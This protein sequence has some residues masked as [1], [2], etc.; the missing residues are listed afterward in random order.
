MHESIRPSPSE[1]ERFAKVALP[2]PLTDSFTYAIPDEFRGRVFVGCRVEVSF[3]RRLMSGI[4]VDVT[5]E[6]DVSGIK[7]IRRL[8]ETYLPSS[9]IQLTRW[10]ASYYGCSIGEAAQSVLPPLLKPARSRQRLAGRLVLEGPAA[11]GEME[12]VL[13]RAPKQLELAR[14]LMHA[15]GEASIER[16]LGEWGFS[17][18]HVKGLVDK[19]IASLESSEAE[20]SLEAIEKSVTALT[21]DQSQAMA[22]VGRC[23]EAGRFSPVLLH[24][25]TGS[26]KTE[27]YIRAASQAVSMGG[28]CIV[29]VPE[30]GLLPQ[31]TVRYRR[32]FGDG[33]AILHSRLTGAERFAIW[34]SIESGQRRIVLGPR[35]AV[36]GPVRNL[37][38]IIVDEEQDDSYKQDD[39]PRYHARHVALMRGKFEGLT[40][41]LGS[42]TPSAESFHH[43]MTGRYERVTLRSRVEGSV[44]PAVNFV[45]MR[46]ASTEGAFFSSPLLSRLESNIEAGHQSILFLNKRG[47]ARFVQCNTCGW[48]ARCPN[49]DISLTYH[50]V[51]QKLRCHFCGFG[52]PVV[53]RCD[54]CGSP[55]LYFGGV[56]TQR[57]ELDLAAFF[58]GLGILRM[59]ADTTSG[60]KGHQRVL[61]K[62]AGG[63]Y[64]VLIGTQMVAKGHHFPSVNFVGVLFAEEGLNYPDFRS[65]ERTFQQLTQ[66]AGRAGRGGR[67]GEVTIQTYMPDHPVFRF[68]RSH[69]YEGFMSEE[70]AVR[71]QLNYPPFSKIILASCTSP[72]RDVL[73]RVIT[74]WAEATRQRLAP[75]RIDVLGPVPP[76]VAR[77]KNR[78]REQVLIKGTL[79]ERDKRLVLDDFRKAVERERAGRGVEIRWDVDPETFL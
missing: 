9:L 17:R 24:G 19:G 77:V 52:R 75:K 11:N 43:A 14:V 67:R 65:A 61:E 44:L 59:D 10:I 50:R 31:A 36:F 5:G 20:S 56:G 40:I 23:L 69:D 33:I 34:K 32:V 66:V 28:G 73:N 6:T 42:A 16:V 22:L 71:K 70:L 12:L 51:S 41:L 18:E 74:R 21:T 63:E 47:H 79:S 3:G 48:A 38:L 26:G 39:K 45:D 37:K 1:H 78:Y 57:I 29:L 27:V 15:G 30:I 2:V 46:E 64:S 68:L 13:R 55:K 60:K 35:S 4:V 53:D 54:V 72:K 25:V 62:F 49:C 8:Y 58:P 76:L 7:P